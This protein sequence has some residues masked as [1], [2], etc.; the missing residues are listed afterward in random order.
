MCNQLGHKSSDCPKRKFTP[1][2]H[3]IVQEEEVEEGKDDQD[4]GHVPEPVV[5]EDE[6]DLRRATI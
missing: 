6:A 4:L 5:Y 1:Q 3:M 2:A